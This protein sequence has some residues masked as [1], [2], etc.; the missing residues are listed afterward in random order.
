MRPGLNVEVLELASKASIGGQRLRI[1]LRSQGLKPSIVLKG[2]SAPPA[3]WGPRSGILDFGNT[4]AL[5]RNVMKFTIENSSSFAV[6]VRVVRSICVGLSP[7]RQ[8][9]LIDRTA[10]G[11]PIFLYRPERVTIDQG[12]SQVIEVIFQP[13]R[14][15]FAPF[16]EDLDVI[17]GQS[18]EMLKVGLCGRGWS[19]QMFI[20]PANP[21]DEP[22]AQVNLPGGS[23]VS[24]VEDLLSTHMA[25]NV[26]TAAKKAMSSIRVA[27]PPSPP[28]Q[29]EFPDP[30]APGADPSSYVEA[31]ATGG[32]KAPAKGAPATGGGGSRQQQRRF[33]VCCAKALDGR[34]GSGNGTFEVQLSAAAKES[35][36]WQLSTDKG[37]VTAGAEVSVDVTCTLPKPKNIGGLAVGSWQNYYAD[38]VI[39]G[40]WGAPE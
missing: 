17:V 16:R 26:R 15:R 3:A 30:F 33:N 39:K 7:A 29:L 37:A 38:V 9:E 36:L 14:G 12:S 25:L 32:G 21:L 22:F 11:L 19:R 13:D 35:G 4:L 31:G 34:P 6:D 24:P 2:L 18:D 8:A 23:G 28:M 1:T 10:G 27:L 20:T 40:G 5:D